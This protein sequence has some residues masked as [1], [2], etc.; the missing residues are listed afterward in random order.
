MAILG[1]IKSGVTSAGQNAAQQ[2]KNFAEVAKLNSVNSEKEKKIAQLY[3]DIGKSY[4]E[5]HRQDGDAEESEK[6][7]KINAL[8]DEI[9]QNREKIMQIK[10]VVKCEKCGA[11][12]P[13]DAAFCSHCGEKVNRGAM[14]GDAGDE[15]RCP[16]C[17]AVVPEG[18]LYCMECGGKIG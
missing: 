12:V 3:S 11:D 1:R 8:F 2:T 13:I 4:Y 16:H 14:S 5:R 7:E 6:I 15:R 18:N 17:N 10:G 9:A